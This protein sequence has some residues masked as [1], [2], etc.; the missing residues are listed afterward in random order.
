MQPKEIMKYNFND[1]LGFI[2]VKAGRLIEN[3]LKT[4][5]ER[6]NIDVTPQQW[7]V[8]TYLWNED[9]ISQQNLAD[10]F[11]KDKTSMTRLLNNMEKND[12]IVRKQDEQDKRNKKIYLTFKSKIMKKDTIKIAEKTLMDTLIGIEHKDLRLSKKILKQINKNLEA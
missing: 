6:E 9:G 1:S 7:S 10:A 12:L 4:D 11:S 2:I 3:K 5:F 8:L